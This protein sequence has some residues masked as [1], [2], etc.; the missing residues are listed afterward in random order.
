MLTF[1]LGKKGE[2]SNLIT[3]LQPHVVALTEI[4]PKNRVK[5]GLTESAFSSGV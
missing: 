2:L 4:N 5:D 3:K 1:L